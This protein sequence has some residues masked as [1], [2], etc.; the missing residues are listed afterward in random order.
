MTTVCEPAPHRPAPEAVEPPCSL[1][2]DPPEQDPPAEQDPPEDDSPATN[3]TK[4]PVQP[5]D[6]PEGGN[7]HNPLPVNKSRRDPSRPETACVTFYGYRHYDP[8]T[9]RWP[10]RD[11]IGETGGLNLYG[12][13]RNSALDN[14]DTLG[15]TEPLRGAVVKR[16]A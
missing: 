1:P 16:I 11:P 15:W 12:F 10:S 14:I 4:S 3:L 8:V 13:V 6:P 5:P 7:P 2:Q 9:G